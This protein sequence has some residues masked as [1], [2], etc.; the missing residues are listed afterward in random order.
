MDSMALATSVATLSQA[1]RAA[2]DASGMLDDLLVNAKFKDGTLRLDVKHFL[3]DIDA[4]Q[5]R[6]AIP[7]RSEEYGSEEQQ[8]L[9]AKLQTAMVLCAG[10]FDQLTLHARDAGKPKSGIFRQG[11]KLSVKDD[12]IVRAKQRIPVH[13]MTIQ[14]LVA[15]FNVWVDRVVGSYEDS[16]NAASQALFSTRASLLGFAG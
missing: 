14:L 11:R 2:R 5:S 15:T 6:L 9:H 7:E 3:E 16:T 1:A 8:A 10:T 4:L 13:A 12:A